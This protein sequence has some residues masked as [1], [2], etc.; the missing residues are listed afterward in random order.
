MMPWYFSKRDASLKFFADRGQKQVIAGYYDSDPAK[1]VDWLASA[2]KVPGSVTGVMYTTW[3]N[4]YS[5]LEK[6]SQLVD[7]GNQ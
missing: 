5:D 2:K 7:K 6:F 3:Q 4:N 1:V